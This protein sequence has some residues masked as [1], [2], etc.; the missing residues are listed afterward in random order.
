MDSWPGGRG[1]GS[2]VGSRAH[3]TG[4]SGAGLGPRHTQRSRRKKTKDSQKS[5]QVAFFCVFRVSG[6]SSLYRSRCADS[7]LARPI[8]DKIV[9]PRPHAY[10]LTRFTPKRCHEWPHLHCTTRIPMKYPVS[11][12][13]RMN[14][15]PTIA[16][17]LSDQAN[18]PRMAV[19]LYRSNKGFI[20]SPVQSGLCSR[21]NP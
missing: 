15:P 6:L 19:C 5:L 4:A 12:L 3:R 21:E 7:V 13:T 20:L 2:F 17:Y 18:E 14:V 1:M 8:V 10:V 9:E 16:P 11:V